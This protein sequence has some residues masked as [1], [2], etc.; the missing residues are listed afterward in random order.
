[1]T[2]LL[3]MTKKIMTRRDMTATPR[4]MPATMATWDFSR[5]STNPGW[6]EGGAGTVVGGRAVKNEEMVK[7]RNKN[8]LFAQF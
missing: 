8:K 3:K 5:M 1:M 4:T 2:D 7:Q 6:P